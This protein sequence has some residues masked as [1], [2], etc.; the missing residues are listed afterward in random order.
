[1]REWEQSMDQNGAQWHRRN[2]I[3]LIKK[4]EEEEE[5]GRKV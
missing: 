3:L 1:M 2:G 4:E 5:G